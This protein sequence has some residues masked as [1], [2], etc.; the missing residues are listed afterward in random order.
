[1]T[2]LHLNTDARNAAADAVVDLIDGGSGAG[3]I[4][5]YDGTAPAGADVA[6]TT[7]NLLATLTFSDPAFGSAVTG[8]ATA[9][10]VTSGTAVYSS[11]A[12]WARIADSSGTAIMDVDVGT[13]GATLLLNTTNIVSGATVS[14]TSSTITMPTGA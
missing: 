10:T 6:V 9:D 1:M 4:K 2:W 13:T 12:T 7:Q 3:T 5:I 8:E 14:V 11:T